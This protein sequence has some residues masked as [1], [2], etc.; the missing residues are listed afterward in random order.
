MTCSVTACWRCSASTTTSG[1]VRLVAIGKCRQV[2][3]SCVSAFSVRTRRTTIGRPAA[4]VLGDLRDPGV[5]VVVKID[6]G[7]LVDG[8]DGGADRRDTPDGD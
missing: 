8:L 6:P 1:S 7:V 3:N 2:A 4:M 5:R